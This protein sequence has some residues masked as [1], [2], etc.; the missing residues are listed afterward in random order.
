MSFLVRYCQNKIRS[1]IPNNL[2]LLLQIL[3]IRYIVSNLN[4]GI[5]LEFLYYLRKCLKLNRHLLFA[6]KM[7]DSHFDMF[8]RININLINIL[9]LYY[10]HLLLNNI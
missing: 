3:Y 5:Y 10:I 9:N 2:I 1:V 4:F 6:M 7:S 8:L